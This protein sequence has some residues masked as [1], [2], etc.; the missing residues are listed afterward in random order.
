MAKTTMVEPSESVRS[1][2][3]SIFRNV[4][5]RY[6]WFDRDKLAKQFYT[7]GE[8]IEKVVRDLRA[9]GYHIERINENGKVAYK[10]HK[11]WETAPEV[12]DDDK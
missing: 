9:H 8:Y 4:A 11:S 10:G 1:R 7:T 6:D 5:N 2:I 3:E 12:A